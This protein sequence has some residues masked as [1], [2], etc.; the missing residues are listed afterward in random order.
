MY[1][2]LFSLG[3]FK[4]YSYGFF[5]ALAFMAA[6]FYLSYS[7][8]KTREKLIQYD[9]LYSLFTY[10]AVFAILGARSLFI[11]VNL[12][13]FVLYPLDVLKIWN[14]GLVYYGGFISA[15]IFTLIYAKKK[16]M[17]IFN[18]GDFF[19]PALALG[20]AI[21]RIGC[22]F[23]GCCYGKE[24]NLPWAVVFTDK[25]SLAVRGVYIHA[26][27]LYESIVNFILFMFLHF[28]S[29]KNTKVPGMA[30]VTYLVIYATSRFIIE[31]FRDNCRGIHCFGFSISQIISVFLFIIGVLIIWK[32]KLYIKKLKGRD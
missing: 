21:G 32:K 29:K 25:Y 2:I 3:N 27:Q 10:M 7:I 28:Y 19:V 1:P 8:K 16:K 5:V 6:I 12:R 4:I 13:D 14:G 24:T 9:E 20:H 30:F 26:T 18:L 15:A 31:F 17:M 23:A 22:F 11:F